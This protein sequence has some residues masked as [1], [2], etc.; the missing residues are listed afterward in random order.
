MPANPEDTFIVVALVS[1]RLLGLDLER[2][3]LVG[4]EG[5]PQFVQ[6]TEQQRSQNILLYGVLVF[7][8]TGDTHVSV[9]LVD[10]HKRETGIGGNGQRNSRGGP[11]MSI[12]VYLELVDGRD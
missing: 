7:F 5:V 8:L 9:V 12:G 6:C 1:S 2:I 10:R 4:V 11:Q 3:I